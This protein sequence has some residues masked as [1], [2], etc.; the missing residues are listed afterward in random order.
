MTLH[1]EPN[2]VLNWLDV[3][4]ELRLSPAPDPDGD[5]D[6]PKSVGRLNGRAVVYGEETRLIGDIFERIDSGA[7]TQS[8]ASDDI[9]ALWS[10]DHSRI[11]GRTRSRTLRLTESDGGVGVEIDLPDTQI[12]RDARESVLRGD[13]TG[14]SMGFVVVDHDVVQT[15][16]M[17]LRIVKAGRLL[18]VSPVIWPAYTSTD[19]SARED[20]I[21]ATISHR[22]RPRADIDEL[23]GMRE[24]FRAESARHR[25]NRNA[26]ELAGAAISC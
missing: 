19:V 13:V 18:E 20:G 1:S 23:V 4:C 16:D 24:R 21:D 8:L 6:A 3:P 12:G 22:S 5:T 9:F 7:F 15:D 14:M 11:L 2:T 26:L 17:M 25:N 10:H